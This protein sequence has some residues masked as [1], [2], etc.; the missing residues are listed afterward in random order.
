MKQYD[1]TYF[2]TIEKHRLDVLATLQK[3]NNYHFY[4]EVEVEVGGWF[5]EYIKWKHPMHDN[6]QSSDVFTSYEFTDLENNIPENSITLDI[7]ADTGYYSVAYSLYSD[8]VIAFEPNPVSFEILRQNVKLN[9][10]IIAYN[11]GCA[12]EDK[13]ETFWY[14]DESLYGSGDGYP[15]DVYLA[16]LDKFLKELHPDYL[17]KI[18]F[19]HIGFKK[20]DVVL[21]VLSEIIEKNKPKII[22]KGNES[23]YKSVIQ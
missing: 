9:P 7:G 8:K 17:D 6:W 16:N 1:R 12:E 21:S 14:R 23:E 15:S 2:K 10:N 11:I 18:G 20:H 5:V 13:K 22:T 4:D 19:I 3:T